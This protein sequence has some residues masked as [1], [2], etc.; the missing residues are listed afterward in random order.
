MKYAVRMTS[1]GMIYIPVFIKIGSG[2][3]KL[4]GGINIQ[5]HIHTDSKV[6]S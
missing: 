1:G 6:I 2:V 5:T 4:L 3:Q